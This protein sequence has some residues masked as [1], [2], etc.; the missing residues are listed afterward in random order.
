M[1]NFRVSV[2]LYCGPSLNSFV[3]RHTVNT[4]AASETRPSLSRDA[5]TLLFGRTPGPEG[6]GDIYISTRTAVK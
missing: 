2:L 4:A 1:G 3:V 5:R 6:I